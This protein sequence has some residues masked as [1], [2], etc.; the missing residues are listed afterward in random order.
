VVVGVLAGWPIAIGAITLGQERALLIGNLVAFLFCLRAAV[1]LRVEGRR[2]LTP[3]V[4]ELTFR[5]E[6]SFSF[7]PGQ[8]LELD[9]PHRR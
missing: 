9:V 8:Y 1:R 4:R 7:S 2:D 6:R 5:A 3:T